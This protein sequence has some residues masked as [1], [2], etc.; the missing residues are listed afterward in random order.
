MML[1]PMCVTRQILIASWGLI[2]QTLFFGGGA[3]IINAPLER[4]WFEE[5]TEFVD[6]Y[7]PTSEMC[8]K[9]MIKCLLS[10]VYLL[11]Q[12]LTQ[13]RMVAT[14]TMKNLDTKNNCTR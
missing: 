6:W 1:K 9:P 11:T 8:E 2:N 13:Q 14:V 3:E 10:T 7:L 12:V 5:S 4:V